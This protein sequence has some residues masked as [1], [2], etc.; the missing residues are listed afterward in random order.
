MQQLEKQKEDQDTYV[1]SLNKQLNE[2][3]E[4]TTL[5][6]KQYE[7]QKQETTDA[8]TVLKDTIRE[9]ELISSEKKQLMMQW[10]S[11]LSGLSRRDEALAQASLTLAAAESAVHDYDVQIEASR[12]DL[13][14]EQAKHESLVNLRDRLE[15]ELAW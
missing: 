10:K 4:Q 7:T 11:A 9:L 12:R 1:D 6:I 13:Q 14:R 8:N 5:F 3:K 2:L 15:N